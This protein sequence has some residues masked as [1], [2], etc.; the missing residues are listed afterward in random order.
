M[1]WWMGKVE[2]ICSSYSTVT[3]HNTHI[4]IDSIS[5]SFL[6]LLCF[7]LTILALYIMW[8]A[9]EHWWS[10]TTENYDMIWW[11]QAESG[12]IKPRSVMP[13]CP[14]RLRQSPGRRRRDRGRRTALEDQS[15]S[16]FVVWSSTEH[17]DQTAYTLWQSSRRFR[18]R[19]LLCTPTET[20]CTPAWTTNHG[21]YY[22]SSNQSQ[23]CILLTTNQNVLLV[24]QTP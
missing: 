24:S 8:G 1:G 11:T 15:P 17:W 7:I 12:I 23:H 18:C 22:S 4:L 20:T 2:K 9:T 21:A 5:M 14:H 16:M 19:S 10:G 3:Q 13:S 6:F